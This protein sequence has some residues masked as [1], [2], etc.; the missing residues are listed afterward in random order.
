[1][2]LRSLYTNAFPLISLAN[3]MGYVSIVC[4]VERVKEH[5]TKN[6]DMMAFLSVSDESG[7]FDVVCMPNIYRNKI[8]LL[9]RGNYLYMEGKIDKPGSMLV[10]RVDK[11][12]LK[13]G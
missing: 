9:K 12:D 3:K 2:E 1:M 11:V 8:E 10:N 5:R 13:K 4:F 7:K 6:G